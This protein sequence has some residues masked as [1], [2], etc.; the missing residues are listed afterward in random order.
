MKKKIIF[1]AFLLFCQN[2]LLFGQVK[3]TF[4]TTSVPASKDLSV[5]LFLAGDFNG[6][7]PSDKASEMLKDS[8]GYYQVVKTWAPGNYSFKV[9]RGD[10]QKVESSDKGR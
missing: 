7:D 8:T 1:C 2:F 6:W 3:V 5:H 4:K 9:T 10:W